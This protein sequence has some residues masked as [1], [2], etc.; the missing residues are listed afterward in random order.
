MD[1]TGEIP[2]DRRIIT[3]IGLIRAN[4]PTHVYPD[5]ISQ[6]RE[7]HPYSAFPTFTR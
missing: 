4:L 7:E 2:L 6:R 3:P 1:G 5:D